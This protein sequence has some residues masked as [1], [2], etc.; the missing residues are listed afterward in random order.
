MNIA[1]KRIIDMMRYKSSILSEGDVV[2]FTVEDEKSIK[3]WKNADCEAFIENFDMRGINPAWD[4]LICPF[5]F[6][7]KFILLY[8]GACEACSYG[9]RHGVCPDRDSS[10][11][12]IIRLHQ[13]EPMWSIFT[14]KQKDIIIAILEGK[15]D[16][17][18]NLNVETL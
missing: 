11:D 2:Y 18:K 5:C 12:K 8:N 9:K 3:S 10:Y 14:Y 7:Y 13:K 4:I 6:H 15:Y 17:V 16:H 1:K